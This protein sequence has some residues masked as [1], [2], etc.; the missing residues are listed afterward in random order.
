MKQRL[1]QRDG[2][3]AAAYHQRFLFSAFVCLA[4]CA[5]SPAYA[6]STYPTKPIRLLV[7]APAG[8][9][10]DLMARLVMRD[11]GTQL[12][13]H[14]VIEN[15]RNGVISD[16]QVA[17]SAPDGYTLTVVGSQHSRYA[18]LYPELPYDLKNDF[19]CIGLIANA[20]YVLVVHPSV[21][22]RNVRE[23]IALLKNNAKGVNYASAGTGSGQHL[24][25]EL[26]KRMAGVALDHV[27][28]RGSALALPDLL[29][30][31]IPIMFDNITLMLPHISRG[32]L[33]PLAI[34]ATQRS[35][36]LPDVPTIAASGLAGFEVSGWFALLG[37]AAIPQDRVQKLNQGLNAVL[38]QPSIITALEER[39]ALPMTGSAEQCNSFIL[40]EIDKWGRVIREAGIKMN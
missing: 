23:L 21:P 32:A 18:A 29:S 15:S 12:Q 34:T 30:G 24:S 10:A 11:V 39:G 31:R 7:G 8:G 3:H 28:Y 2:P 6:Q 4:A 9:T 27:P 38:A 5:T 22:V 36:L 40:A 33:R 1:R 35:R 37:A 25:G 20:P 13:A 26:F 17:K 14:F 19:S 16:D